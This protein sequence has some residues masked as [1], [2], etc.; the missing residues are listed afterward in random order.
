LAVSLLRLAAG[1]LRLVSAGMRKA[2]AGLAD[3]AM[4]EVC[5]GCGRSV[6]D[7]DGL[8]G[9]CALRL[10]SLVALN[11]CPRCGASIGPGVPASD[12]G[13]AA[14]PVPVGRFARVV[15]LGPYAD[16]LRQTLRE[17]KYRS[18]E[19][20]VRR[21][22][23]MLAA[24]IRARCPN[25]DFDLAMPVPMHWRRRLWRGHDHSRVLAAAL[26]RELRLPVG[27]ELFRVRHTPQ[28]AHL[29][30][31][32]RIQNMRGAFEADGKSLNGARV[33]LV[34]DITTTGAT[35]SEAARA[36]L[37]AGAL[38]VTLAVAAKSEPRRAYSERLANP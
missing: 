38:R 7:E 4:P 22:A 25:E 21:L 20:M 35:A 32:R 9:E 27:N 36:L 23:A 29:P 37:S 28:Q 34:D 3:L 13:C 2:A 8:C 17:L 24:A 5:V 19:R 6:G 15:R 30:R 31:T 12:E 11:Y 10:L 26:A 1:P 16:P 14:C 18:N 33:L